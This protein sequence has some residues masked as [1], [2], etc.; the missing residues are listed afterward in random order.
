MFIC[1][2]F[3]ASGYCQVNF[4]ETFLCHF[5]IAKNQSTFGTNLNS[6]QGSIFISQCT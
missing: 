1:F 6:E 2:T 3:R 4:G 5:P